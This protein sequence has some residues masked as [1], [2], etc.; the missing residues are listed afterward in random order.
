MSKFNI[1]NWDNA[2]ITLSKD[3]IVV[4]N[5]YKSVILTY[6]RPSDNLI[7]YQ[8]IKD[9]S[10]YKQKYDDQDRLVYFENCKGLWWKKEYR[11]DG[12]FKYYAEKDKTDV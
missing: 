3:L 4:V 10:W 12:T 11:E 8:N 9:G 7:H 2:L 6:E 5:E 1:N